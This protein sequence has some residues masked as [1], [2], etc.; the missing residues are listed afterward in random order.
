MAASEIATSSAGSGLFVCLS[1][2]ATNNAAGYQALTFIEVGEVTNIGEIGRKY[3]QVTVNNL[4]Q[5]QTRILKG[6]YTEGAPQITI[7]YAPGDDGQ[8]AML[9]ALNQDGNVS[10]KFELQDGTEKFAQG[11]VL[12]A[13]FTIGGVDDVTSGT[14]DI[15]LNTNIVTVL[16][17]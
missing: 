8:V 12:A 5:R 7:N 15:A 17:T 1:L 4:K 11:L 2:P 13:P 16:P 9:A 14:Y 3:N 10:F 6:S